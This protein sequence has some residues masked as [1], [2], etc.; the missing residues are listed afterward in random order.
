MI[1]IKKFRK[2]IL[3]KDINNHKKGEEFRYDSRQGNDKCHLLINN[4][5]EQIVVNR[6][7]FIEAPLIDWESISFKWQNMSLVDKLDINIPEWF[8]DEVSKYIF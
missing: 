7:D 6:T 5:S 1:E 8:K 2:V 3:T 4:K